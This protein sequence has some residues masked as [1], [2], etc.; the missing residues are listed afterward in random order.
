MRHGTPSPARL[1]LACVVA[2]ALAPVAAT[3]SFAGAR[4]AGPV[5]V[6]GTTSNTFEPR[7][8]KATPDADGKITI[9]FTSHNVHTIQ[10]D[11]V[12]GFDSDI[13]ND[14]QTKTI[15]FDAPP[16]GQYPVYCELHR[17]TMTGTL[18][19]A[20]EA[21]E[22]PTATATAE[23][24]AEPT[25]SAPPASGTA[26]PS[27]GTGEDDAPEPGEH[28]EGSDDAAHDIPGVADNPTLKRIEDERAAQATAVSGFKFFTFVSIAFLFI[29][30]AAILFST[31][32]RRGA[33]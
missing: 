20:G 6:E 16:P 26:S 17:D 23:P 21:A 27:T 33:R 8:I 2:C 30:G 28:E 14:G 13:V 9:E 4:Q 15:T 19:V 10:S 3:A 24:T 5:K 12:P 18:T 22:S 31:R 1:L 7:D 32:P 25:A 29:L 11:E